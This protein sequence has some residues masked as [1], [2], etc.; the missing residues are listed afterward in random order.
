MLVLSRLM[1]SP[2]TIKRHQL[3]SADR[4]IATAYTEN[5]VDSIFRR[6]CFVLIEAVGEQ[7]AEKPKIERGGVG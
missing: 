7:F 5:S 6:K 3:K 4:Q 1:S 2:L